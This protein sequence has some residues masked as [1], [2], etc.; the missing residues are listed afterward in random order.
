MPLVEKVR[1]GSKAIMIAAKIHSYVVLHSAYQWLPITQSWL[2]NQILHLPANIKSHIVCEESCNLEQFPTQNLYTLSQEPRWRSILEKSC[3]KVGVWRTLPFIEQQVSYCQPQ[4]LHS[5]FGNYGWANLSVAQKFQLKHLVTFY[6]LDVNQL[7]QKDHRWCSRYREMFQHVDRV[8]CEGP[9]M[10][11]CIVQLGCPSEKVTVH[12]LGVN[13]DNLPFQPRAWNSNNPLRILMAAS[14]REKKGLPYALQA[15]GQL[16]KDVSLEITLIGDCGSDKESQCEKQRILEIIHQ[17]GL[18]IKLLGYQPHNVFLQEAYQHHLFF[19]P[20]VT[21]K[22]GD[23]EGGAPVSIIEVAAS[24]MP[25]ISTHHCDIPE[26]LKPYPEML[27]AEERN[28]NDLVRISRWWIGHSKNWQRILSETRHYIET[29]FDAKHQGQ[30]LG[31][32]YQ[33]VM[34]TTECS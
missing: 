21:A 11:Q 6:G 14:F 26:V 15:L 8:L 28:V 23:T 32:I 3:R 27:L 31:I 16:S 30:K 9:Y 19:S 12:H 4:I 10:A 25:V 7:P 18:N 5:H 13:L 34:E 1:S 20:S 2:Y 17:Y 33:G 22:D 29:E 24:G